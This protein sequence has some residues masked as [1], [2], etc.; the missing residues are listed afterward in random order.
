MNNK[1]TIVSSIILLHSNVSMCLLIYKNVCVH[2]CVGRVLSM[3]ER[4]K[5]KG[6]HEVSP[7]KN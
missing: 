2:M 1:R 4:K 7:E 5:K 3:K 6:E